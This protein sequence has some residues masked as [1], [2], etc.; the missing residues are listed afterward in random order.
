[1][2]WIWRKSALFWWY[3]GQLNASA[4]IRNKSD[5]QIPANLSTHTVF[6]RLYD[7]FSPCLEWLQITKT[8]PLNFAIIRVV[9]FLKNLKDLDPSYKMDLDHWDCFGRKK[10]L[11]YIQRK[12]VSARLMQAPSIKCTH[13]RCRDGKGKTAVVDK[14][15]G[16]PLLQCQI[17]W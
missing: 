14:A 13:V 7:G 9:P 4:Y 2:H 15:P 8:V 5:S 3:D 10:T 17:S 6:I 11:S 1:M 16:V 12:T